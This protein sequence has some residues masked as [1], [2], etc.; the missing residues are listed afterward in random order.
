[1]RDRAE[2]YVGMGEDEFAKRGIERVSVHTISCRQNQIGG[3]SVPIAIT[4]GN[5]SDTLRTRTRTQSQKEAE[6]YMVYP[7]ATISLPGLNTSSN[8]PFESGAFHQDK[9]RVSNPYK[10]KRDNTNERSKRKNGGGVGRG[11]KEKGRN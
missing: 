2:T 11:R 6:T 8:V 9:T 1:M 5:H 3:G 7:A 4:N 10:S